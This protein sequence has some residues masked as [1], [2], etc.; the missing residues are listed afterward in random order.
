MLSWQTE[1][2]WRFELPVLASAPAF[3]AAET[4]I[5]LGAG[6]GAF[7]RRLA[8]AYPEKRFLGLEPNDAI[9]AVGAQ[10]ASPPNYRYVHGG[11][12]SVAEVHDLL[13]ARLV[14]MYLRDRS[15]LYAWAQRHV[16]AAIV[17]N[18]DDALCAAEPALPLVDAAVAEG[19]RR[20]ADELAT[21]HVGD[22]DLDDMQDEWAAAGFVPAASTTVVI[23]VR[24]ADDRRLYHHLTRLV[25]A[26]L[27]PGA[28]TRALL[29]EVY[30][31]SVD[32]NARA[33]S[34]LAY[35]SVLNPRLAGDEV[36]GTSLA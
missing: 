12:E 29:D 3:L 23:D 2:C 17:V 7:G 16:R 6:N 33:V 27:N 1:L 20:G 5:D 19:Q 14:I 4:I 15:A 13:F 28:V 25:V 30:L 24:D 21:T 8:R 34:G 9:Y 36:G 32:P 35:H 31:W 11:Y 22:R 26:G 18:S 10:S